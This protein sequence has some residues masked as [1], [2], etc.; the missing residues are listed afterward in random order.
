LRFGPGERAQ[1]VEYRTDAG[2]EPLVI[3][4]PHAA[5]LCSG[6]G[7]TT[8]TTSQVHLVAEDFGKVGHLLVRVPAAGQPGQVAGSGNPSRLELAV[9]VRGQRVQAIEATGQHSP[10]LAGFDLARAAGTIAA[11]GR[12]E[13]AVDMDG[14]L[15]PVG[16]VRPR[17]LAPGVELLASGPGLPPDLRAPR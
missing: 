3:T 14:V 5:V 1:V 4:P 9:L 11:H 12:A 17:R 6:T 15:M 8:W 16:Y 7:V 10:G 2:P 13:L